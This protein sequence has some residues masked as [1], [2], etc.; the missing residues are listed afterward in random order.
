M[1]SFSTLNETSKPAQK[2]A[3]I[4]KIAGR[5]A[6]RYIKI[7][8]L[9]R[10]IRVFRNKG[11]CEKFAETS[12]FQSRAVERHNRKGTNWI[13]L[14]TFGSDRR[15]AKIWIKGLREKIWRRIEINPWRS[16]IWIFK[17]NSGGSG[18]GNS[19]FQYK[20]ERGELI[21][22]GTAIFS[23]AITGFMES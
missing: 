5:F 8:K 20:A 16:K 15:H 3:L 18:L 22:V 10:Q 17:N 12:V 2:I 11:F 19:V 13:K 7:F 1:A 6:R 14:N 9:S 23:A 4:T 21:L